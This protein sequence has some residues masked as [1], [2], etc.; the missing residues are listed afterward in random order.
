ME[1]TI[2]TCDCCGKEFY[3]ENNRYYYMEHNNF[4]NNIDVMVK[5]GVKVEDIVYKICRN[6][7]TKEFDIVEERFNCFCKYCDA[8][9]KQE[10]KEIVCRE[11]EKF[12]E[13]RRKLDEIHD[14]IVDMV[15]DFNK[16]E[17]EYIGLQFGAFNYC[18]IK[19]ENKND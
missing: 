12:N 11:V 1:L 18:R 5:L 6:G 8:Y 9:K 3:G 14:N 2:M 15:K 7:L 4:I 13:R 10:L 17:K 16:T 19:K